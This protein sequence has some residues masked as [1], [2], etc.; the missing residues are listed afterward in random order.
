MSNEEKMKK[1]TKLHRQFAHPTIEKLMKL[2]RSSKFRDPEFEKCLEEVTK[3]CIFCRKHK[4]T[5]LKPIVGFNLADF[6]NDVV[7]MD[8]KE[9]VHNRTWILHL[10][11]AATRYSA[12]CLINNKHKNTVVAKIFRMWIAY[13][14][15]SKKMFSD[16]GGEFN[17]DVFREM[18][19]KLNI[20]TTTTSAESPF[21][22]GTVER[23]NV[24]L[25]E[26]MQKTIDD[27]GCDPET[28]LAWAVSAKTLFIQYM[29]FLQTSLSLGS[30]CQF[31]LC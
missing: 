24:I 26:S 12:A 31:Q 30:M 10:I 19:E 3:G 6:F 29:D 11:D 17:N 23:H 28:A 1:A 9:H 25:F 20:E 13:F 2:V 5:P 7:C 27:V 21:S 14:G 8:L 4:K 15:C 16:N 22:N 18:N